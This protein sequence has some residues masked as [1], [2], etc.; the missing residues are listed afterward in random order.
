MIELFIIAGAV[1]SSVEGV[2][3]RLGEPTWDRCE[4]CNRE[5]PHF[6]QHCVYRKAVHPHRQYDHLTAQWYDKP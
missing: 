2:C 6:G 5:T 1:A 3:A 4:V